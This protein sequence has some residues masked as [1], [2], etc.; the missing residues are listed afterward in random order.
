V[1]REFLHDDSSKPVLQEYSG[2][3]LLA[4]TRRMLLHDVLRLILC[5]LFLIR[6]VLS[7]LDFH[8]SVSESASTLLLPTPSY[9]KGLHMQQCCKCLTWLC[10]E[11]RIETDDAV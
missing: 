10:S 1:G 5:L 8:G 2:K 11:A 9:G 7:D 6:G 4:V 3:M